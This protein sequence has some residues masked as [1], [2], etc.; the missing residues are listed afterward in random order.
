MAPQN[1]IFKLSTW[2]KTKKGFQNRKLVIDFNKQ[3]ITLENWKRLLDVVS[4]QRYRVRLP[5]PY[6][7]ASTLN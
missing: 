5:C 2:K 1:R 4:F 6:A 3:K 7:T